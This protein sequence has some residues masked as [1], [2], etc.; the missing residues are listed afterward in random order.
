MF[1]LTHGHIRTSLQ[2]PYSTNQNLR[3]HPL[4]LEGSRYYTTARRN[5]FT[6]RVVAEWNKLPEEVVVSRTIDSFKAR[7]DRHWSA[8]KNIFEV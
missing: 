3:G 5:F 2:I 7:L 6:N 1:K 4:K 8:V